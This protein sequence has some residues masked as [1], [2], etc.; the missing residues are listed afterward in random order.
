M[1]SDFWANYFFFSSPSGEKDVC[2]KPKAWKRKGWRSEDSQ[3]QL[4]VSTSP[5]LPLGNFLFVSCP[6]KQSNV[7]LPKALTWISKLQIQVLP[8]TPAVQVQMIRR[9]AAGILF[10]WLVWFWFVSLLVCLGGM[11]RFFI[12]IKMKVSWK[13]P[14]LNKLL[15]TKFQDSGSDWCD[16]PR[17]L[18]NLP[19]SKPGVAGQC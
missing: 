19:G 4:T 17:S 9:S 16:L 8:L 18:E 2:T 13:H 3:H 6:S 15:T 12:K 1:K 7:L 10:A 14:S 5:T 11:L